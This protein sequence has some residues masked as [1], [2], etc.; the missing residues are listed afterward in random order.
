M[1]SVTW[2]RFSAQS[3]LKD[4]DAYLKSLSPKY[5]NK[6]AGRVIK[7]YYVWFLILLLLWFT[8]FFMQ[9]QTTLCPTTDP[10]CNRVN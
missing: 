8:F 2:D 4:Q 3:G 1:Q 7:F 9:K 5:H 10:Y 6:T